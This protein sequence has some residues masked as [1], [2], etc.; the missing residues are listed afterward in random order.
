MKGNV[1]TCMDCACCH[2]T[3]KEKIDLFCVK[4]CYMIAEFC[5]GFEEATEEKLV[6]T[7]AFIRVLKLLRGCM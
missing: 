4:G 2:F 1:R 5:I 7:P 3:N 6:L